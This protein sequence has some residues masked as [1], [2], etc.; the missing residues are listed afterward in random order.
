M[1][2]SEEKKAI[3]EEEKKVI[4]VEATATDKDENKDKDQ[5]SVCCGSCS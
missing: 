2:M 5:P 1:D 3:T 4:E